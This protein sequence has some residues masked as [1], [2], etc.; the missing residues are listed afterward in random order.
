MGG[1]ERGEGEGERER[2]NAPPILIAGDFGT[3]GA[4]STIHGFLLSIFQSCGNQDNHKFTIIVSCNNE[5]KE[6]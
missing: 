3:L 5:E 2:S 6:S 4:M 1:G